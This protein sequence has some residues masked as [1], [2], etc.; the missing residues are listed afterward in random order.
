MR[1][2]RDGFKEKALHPNPHSPLLFSTQILA[3]VLPVHSAGSGA[4]A[5][6]SITFLFLYRYDKAARSKAWAESS[7]KGFFNPF[8]CVTTKKAF[9][10]ITVHI[11]CIKTS[12]QKT[13]SLSPQPKKN[14][15]VEG[16]HKGHSS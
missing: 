7:S 9:L 4:L 1:N 10:P 12:G 3:D 6:A 13:Y 16:R 5:Q 2:N 11:R 14:T 15:I 8:N